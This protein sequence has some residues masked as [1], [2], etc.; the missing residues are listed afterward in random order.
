MLAIIWPGACKPDIEFGLEAGDTLLGQTSS[1]RTASQLLSFRNER[2][3]G[4][5]FRAFQP[6]VL[7]PDYH[8]VF[9]QD[10]NHRFYMPTDSHS[11]SV[12]GG[13]GANGSLNRVFKDSCRVGRCSGKSQNS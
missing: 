7:S 5:I 13:F 10:L 1:T 8:R 3:E 2:P 12:L 6:N 9:I 4:S 11:M